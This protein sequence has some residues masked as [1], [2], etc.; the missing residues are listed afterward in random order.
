MPLSTPLLTTTAYS[1]QA[2]WGIRVVLC[3]L[4]CLTVFQGF[5]TTA[6]AHNASQPVACFGACGL[7]AILDAEVTAEA[8]ETCH[9]TAYT[10]DE[11]WAG[12]TDDSDWDLLP[13]WQRSFT[14]TPLKPRFIPLVPAHEFQHTPLRKP[15][16]HWA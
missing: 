12:E 16:R 11:L 9:T 7:E 2:H 13:S 5:Q 6:Q 8:S 15:P 14:V 3:L 10:H 1:T 4:L